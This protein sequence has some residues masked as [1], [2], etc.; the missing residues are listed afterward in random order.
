[1][2]YQTVTILLPNKT[3]ALVPVTVY[4]IP[5]PPQAKPTREAC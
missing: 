3:G 5:M 2:M 4:R 1:M